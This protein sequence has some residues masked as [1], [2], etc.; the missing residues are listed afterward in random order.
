MIN[1]LS[2]LN[3]TTVTIYWL[4]CVI[5]YSLVDGIN[6]SK[7]SKII[8]WLSGAITASIYAG[9]YTFINIC[10]YNIYMHKYIYF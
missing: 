6:M 8:G 5:M 1:H 3:I 2:I 7:T 4:L 9:Y 10:V